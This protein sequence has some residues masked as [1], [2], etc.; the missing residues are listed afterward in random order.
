MS[1]D[2]SAAGEPRPR[3]LVVDD[4][5]AI[6]RMVKLTLAQRYEVFEAGDAQ[7]AIAMVEKHDIEVVVTDV[8]MPGMTGVEAMPLLRAKAKGPMSVLLLTALGDQAHRNAA[9]EAGADDYLAK[10][11]DRRELLLRVQ[12]FVRLGR[13]ERTIRAQL[14]ELSQLTALKD[15][16]VALLVHDL[17]NPLT[18]LRTAFQLISPSIPAEDKRLFQLGESA[19]KRVIDGVSDLLKVRMLE[20]GELPLE[21]TDF[22]GG[23]LLAEVVKTLE[24]AAM[25]FK[26]KLELVDGPAVKVNADHTLITRA[27]ENLV[28]NAVR[29]TR[30]QVDISVVRVEDRIIFTISDRGIGV[31]DFLKDELFDMF[32]SL[33]L[34]NA[35]GRKGHGLGLYLVRLVARAHGGEVKVTDRDG[36]GANFVFS[37]PAVA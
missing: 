2:P 25:G 31:P 15:D 27:M 37:I 19:L 16:L 23:E 18:A 8:T 14:G 24:A 22:V 17:R 4:D 35:G 28:M 30:E 12:H 1:A 20:R 29:H 33:A 5:D 7:E 21:R 34:K 6:R 11:V 26:V 13:Q 10:P 9:L 32:G 3:V 36:G